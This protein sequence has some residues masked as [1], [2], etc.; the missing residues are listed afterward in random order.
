MP[1]IINISSEKVA[2]AGLPHAVTVTFDMSL[3]ETETAIDFAGIR[4][5]SN[6]PC[7]KD[8]LIA[9]TDIFKGGILESGVYKRSVNLNIGRRVVPTIKERNINYMIRGNIVIEGTDGKR[10]EYFDDQELVIVPENEPVPE[11]KP[12]ILQIKNIKI[13]MEKD[14]YLKGESIK[15]EYE[16]DRI[17]TLKINLVKDVNVYCHCPEYSKCIYTKSTENKTLKTMEL[18][19]PPSSDVLTFKLPDNIESSHNWKWIGPS[20]TYFENSIGD[21]VSY[22][23]GITGITY[24]NEIISLS[25]PITVVEPGGEELFVGKKAEQKPFESI[26]SPKNIELISSE[27]SENLIKFKLKNNSNQKLEGVTITITGIQQALFETLPWVVGKREWAP[28]EIIEISYN[29]HDKQTD[30]YQ[31]LIETNSGIRVK[32]I[33]NI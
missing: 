18:Q 23:I 15:I 8:I 26:F 2:I 10:E 12:M 24:D 7:K 27:V 32:K 1:K 20:T 16:L 30:S 9:K 29:E 11:Y 28:G 17:K 21:S 13:K 33:E 4:L 25:A 14:I 5:I 19:N 22:N 6:R 31:F 3:L